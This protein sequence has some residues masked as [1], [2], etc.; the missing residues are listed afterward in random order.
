MTFS[1]AGAPDGATINSRTGAFSWTP[2]EDVEAT[3]YTFDVVVTDSGSPAE[4][5]KK[6]V[7]ISLTENT[8]KYVKL[9]AVITED[10]ER[11]AWLYD[12]ST[13]K[14]LVVKEGSPFEAAGFSGFVYVIG[15]DFIEFQSGANS[16]RM[17]LGKFLT[18]RAELNAPEIKPEATPTNTAEAKKP[19]TK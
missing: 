15:Q 16:F 12:I 18:E 11:Q 8:Q 2:S 13:K 4:S 5:D 7:T 6:S 10:G 9:I 17:R 1:L 19:T 3:N 14:K